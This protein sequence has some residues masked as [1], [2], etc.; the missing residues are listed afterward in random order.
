MSDEVHVWISSRPRR[1]GKIAYRLR[2]VDPATGKWRGKTAGTDKTLALREAVKVEESISKG[3]CVDLRKVSWDELVAEHVRLIP[4]EANRGEAERTLAE[5]GRILNKPKPRAITFPM[6]EKYVDTL[7]AAK[8]PNSTSTIN[9]KLRYVRGLVKK[10]IR[11][12]YLAKNP[13]DGWQW[14]R[15]DQR[16]IRE[17]TGDEEARLL[18]ATE[19]M[20]GFRYRAFV[21]IA[22]ATGGRREELLQL[23]WADV[24]L[25]G[26]SVLFRNTKGKRD[27]RLYIDSDAVA[28]LR[29]VQAQTLKLG[30]PFV[31]M[32]GTLRHQWEKVLAK[33]GVD[34]V[35]VHD[36]RRTYISRL[37]RSGAV[38]PVVQR[39]A[40][41]ASISTTMKYYTHVNTADLKAASVNVRKGIVG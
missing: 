35:T 31:G 13:M 6:I 33:A 16:E 30:G 27:R 11:R 17:V 21:Q 22:V 41:H 20:L 18:T 25:P 24:D 9:K 3:E 2:W 26:A 19:E 29:K 12:G 38:L 39:L 28:N 36:L 4:G 37:V 8:N 1:S 14:Q 15:E 34:N 32:G 10:A 7:R 40:G 5:F 23:P